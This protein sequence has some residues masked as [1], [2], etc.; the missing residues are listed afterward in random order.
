MMVVVMFMRVVMSTA[1][2][3][4]IVMM[5]VVMFML[6]VV[7]AAALVLI[8]MMV[9]MFMRVVVTAAA[10]IVVI[11]VVVM[12]VCAVLMGL[13]IRRGG[14]PAVERLQYLFQVKDCFVRGVAAGGFLAHD[15]FTPSKN[16]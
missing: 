6:M 15:P 13:H 7:T 12:L 9:V 14:R 10:R 3:V 16:I 2:F 4:L 8:I 5:V 1:A 11:M